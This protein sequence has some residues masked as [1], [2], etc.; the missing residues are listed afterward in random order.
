M[1]CFGNFLYTVRS[2]S[3]RKAVS[4][5]A[6]TMFVGRLATVNMQRRNSVVDVRVHTHIRTYAQVSDLYRGLV[7]RP[8]YHTF[9]VL[10][11]VRGWNI[12]FYCHSK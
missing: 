1:A 2:S 9:K 6:T 7:E 8:C 12:V 5:H 10:W 3:R 11:Q 4:E